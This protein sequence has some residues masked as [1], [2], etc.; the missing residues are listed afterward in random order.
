MRTFVIVMVGL[1][2]WP[3]GAQAQSMPGKFG[4]A[5]LSDEAQIKGRPDIV[6]NRPQSLPGNADQLLIMGKL[7]E[8]RLTECRSRVAVLEQKLVDATELTDLL[9]QKLRRLDGAKKTA[10]KAPNAPK[11]TGEPLPASASAAS[12]SASAT[13]GGGTRGV[14]PALSAKEGYPSDCHRV[15]AMEL[16]VADQMALNDLLERKLQQLQF[17]SAGSG[18]KDGK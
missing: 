17:T 15:E 7:T 6:L 5:R 16:R 4:A 8:E 12:A 9:E 14:Q 1:L 2:W 13:T 10:S 18:S 11:A 3:L